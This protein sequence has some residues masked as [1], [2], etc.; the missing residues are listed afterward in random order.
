MHAST[1]R[2]LTGDEGIDGRR[3]RRARSTAPRSLPPRDPS[4]R[5]RWPR[6][7][8]RLMSLVPAPPSVRRRVRARA[9]H[10]APPCRDHTHTHARRPCSSPR[11]PGAT[12]HRPGW[13][14][15]PQRRSTTPL[16]RPVC[17]LRVPPRVHAPCATAEAWRVGAIPLPRVQPLCR[18]RPA[19]PFLTL[20]ARATGGNK[21]KMS[22]F[23]TFYLGI[24]AGCY[25][26]FGSCLAMTV[27]GACQ[28][29]V[30]AGNLGMRVCFLP[31]SWHTCRFYLFMFMYVYIYVYLSVYLSK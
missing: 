25:I 15:S 3:S 7:A 24:L 18:T 2:L 19:V 13:T 21:A 1:S 5:C 12:R 31:T 29:L 9:C 30:A 20:A 23:K 27:G 17:C 26:A 8:H 16:P 28:G 22:I 14:C 4:Q 10:A 6:A 11:S